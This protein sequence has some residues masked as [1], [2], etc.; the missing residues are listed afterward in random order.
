MVDKRKEGEYFQ[1]EKNLNE[2]NDNKISVKTSPFIYNKDM[3]YIMHKSKE[4]SLES[5]RTMCRNGML[6]ELHYSIMRALYMYTYLNAYLIRETLLSDKKAA[7]EVSPTSARK[8]IKTLVGRG[9]LIQYTFKHVDDKGNEQGSPYIYKL[10]ASGERMVEREQGGFLKFLYPRKQTAD[11]SPF[12]IISV[13]KRLIIN[14]FH[15]TF[16]NQYKDRK[17]LY[18]ADYY[19][20][21]YQDFI[22]PAIYRIQLPSRKALLSMF[23]VAIRS[24]Y[25]WQNEFLKDLRTLKDF[26]DE[27][28]ITGVGILVICET[29]YQ[30]MEAAR[31]KACDSTV[32]SLEVFFICDYI[33]V[34]NDDILSQL[35]EVLPKDNFTSR[36]IFSLSFESVTYKE[37]ETITD[38][39]DKSQE[40]TE[41]NFENKVSLEADNHME[42]S[43]DESLEQSINTETE[44]SEIGDESKVELWKNE[45][46]GLIG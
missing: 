15:I 5:I 26:I 4:S 23:L 17:C 19:K 10:S 20:I 40:H 42:W 39:L 28:V 31:Y 18:S 13:L 3:T 11:N 34:S 41:I 8:A 7:F 14:Q 33:I 36:R 6:T 44:S 30:A 9:L 29:E 27:K 46:D 16:M 24:N 45:I 1:V 37:D 32:K 38:D 43:N 12:E 25:G 35:I 2:D 21:E 22:F